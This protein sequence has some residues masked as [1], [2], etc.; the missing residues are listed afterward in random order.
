[1]EKGENQRN[2]TVHPVGHPLRREARLS[3]QVHSFT[4][5]V[6][7]R[8]HANRVNRYPCWSCVVRDAGDMTTGRTMR[9]KTATVAY[10][11][12]S[13]PAARSINSF[14]NFDGLGPK[15]P[16][17]PYAS[18]P[19]QPVG[20]LDHCATPGLI[21]LLNA[22]ETRSRLHT[23]RLIPCGWPAAWHGGRWRNSA[24]ARPGSASPTRLGTL[25]PRTHRQATVPGR[26]KSSAISASA[27][28]RTWSV[29][30]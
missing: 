14:I 23:V 7:I 20:L 3:D 8:P 21:A 13:K 4:K 5:P 17:R 2:R 9:T 6:R 30:A 12:I 25:S 24:S 10:G 28:I 11:S 15:P 1:M 29:E 27:T 16:R 22:H 18:D 19:N 26:R